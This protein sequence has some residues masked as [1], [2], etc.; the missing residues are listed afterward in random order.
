MG[1]ERPA[2]DDENTQIGGNIPPDEPRPWVREDFDEGSELTKERDGYLAD[3]EAERYD[4][5][6]SCY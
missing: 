1:Q 5:W 4:P 3:A 2:A 6:E